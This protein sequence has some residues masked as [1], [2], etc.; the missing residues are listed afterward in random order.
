MKKTL[1]LSQLLLLASILSFAQGPLLEQ[2]VE[3]SR[4]RG[5]I[6][7]LLAEIGQSGGFT[8]SYGQDIPANKQVRLRESEYSVQTLL[9]ELL[10]SGYYFF[11]FKN[12]ILIKKAADFDETVIVKGKVIDRESKEALPGVTVYLPGTDPLVGVVSDPGGKFRIEVPPGMNIIRFSSI[13]YEQEN[14]EPGS[15]GDKVIELNPERQVIDEVVVEYYRI[16]VDRSINIARA[17]IEDEELSRI[18]LNTIDEALLGSVSGVH[19]VRQT[20]MPGANIMVKIRGIHSLI[21][22]EPSYYLNEFPVQ[23]AVLEAL[24][25]NCIGSIDVIKDAVGT[26]PYGATG[27][28]GVVLLKSREVKENGF[29][30]RFEYYTGVQKLWKTY[31][32]LTGQEFVDFYNQ[33]YND[34]LEIDFDSLQPVDWLNELFHKGKMQE[35]QLS[36][37]GKNENHTVMLDLGYFEHNAMIRNLS[38]ER[39]TVG[40]NGTHS[41][42]NRI[43]IRENL[44]LADLAYIGIKEGSFMNDYSNTILSS[45]MMR[46]WNDSIPPETGQDIFLPLPWDDIE[47]TGNRRSSIVFLGSLD[48]DLDLTDRLSS[49]TR[50]GTEILQQDFLSYTNSPPIFIAGPDF[51]FYRNEYEVNDASFELHQFLYYDFSMPEGQSLK[52]MAGIEYGRM[53]SSWNPNMQIHYPSRE[54]YFKYER[55]DTSLYYNSLAYM[56]DF[57]KQAALASLTYD[58]QSKYNIQ[59]LLRKDWVHFPFNDRIQQPSAWY[60]SAV[61]GWMFNEEDWLGEWNWLSFGKLRA[62]IGSAGNSPK[63]NYSWYSQ[64]TRE[65]EYLIAFNSARTYGLENSALLRQSTEQFYWEKK[66]SANI[67]LDLGFLEN[68]LFFT[69]DYFI[70]YMHMGEQYPADNPLAF[71]SEFSQRRYYKINYPPN[72]RILNQGLEL[73]ISYKESFSNLH[74]NLDFHIA[75]LRNKI[76]EVA[77]LPLSFL[78]DEDYDVISAHIPGHP[79]GSFYGYQIE[80]LYTEEDVNDYGRVVDEPKVWHTNGL[81]ID[82]MAG[83]YKIADLN[84]DTLIDLHDKT[85]LG[86]PIPDLTFGFNWQLEYKGFDLMLMVQGSY[87]NQIFNATRYWLLNPYGQTNWSREILNSYRSPEYDENGVMIDPGNTNTDLHRIDWTNRFRN[88]RISNLFIEDGSYLR[89]K[90]LQ[91]G[92]T[93]KSDWTQKIFIDRFRIYLAAKNL[94]TLTNYTGLDPEIG[95]WG[96]DAGIYPQPRTFLAGVNLEF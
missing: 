63:L 34:P 51:D 23:R 13:G 1:L 20:G 66:T 92:Y 65:L 68:K 76:L 88:M 49:K 28:N 46:P 44:Y 9:S 26:T 55:G 36:L 41:F 84:G 53:S 7:V 8:F 25:P 81:K 83:D 10:G 47:L 35:Y 38:L 4:D 54:H 74:S 16:P 2:K 45:M 75:H 21:N 77:D 50:F 17:R 39:F 24:A 37:S 27:A 94:Y 78:Y 60:P 91:L 32:L 43:R 93:L 85:I 62:G 79:V 18:Q 48:L 70:G 22:S 6:A 42:G 72:A 31:D 89:I 19:T 29:H 52:A 30:A 11:E 80:R 95:G 40:F 3:L 73:D 82:A 67:G 71:I 61:F 64:M 5:T 58:L 14:I 59:L 69:L 96:V 87:G 56:T 90:N 57:H 33:V 12:K 15:A 86:D